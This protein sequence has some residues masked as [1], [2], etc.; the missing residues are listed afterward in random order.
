VRSFGVLAAI[1]GLG[2][3]ACSHRAERVVTLE[4]IP[5][6]AWQQKLQSMK[7]K[8]VVVDVWA[9]WCA[10]CI[11]RFP[12]M[13]QLHDQYK[14]KGVQFVSM[15][16]DDHEDKSAVEKARQFIIQQKAD[17]PNYLMDENIMQAFDKLGV[18]GIPAVFLYDRTGKLRYDLNG[19]DPNR[20]ATLQ[21][22]DDALGKLV[23]GT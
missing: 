23:A 1:V 2:L 3:S 13:V 15:S 7:G 8:I 5:F 16:V 20:Q 11:E 19:D 17:F 22:V 10:P 9:T 21:D 18:Q 6:S 4:P 12:H 14:D